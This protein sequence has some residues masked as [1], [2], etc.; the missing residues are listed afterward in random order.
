M[1]NKET[2]DRTNKELGYGDKSKI[3]RL[4]GIHKL[5][6]NRFF[7]GKEAELK[8]ET[9]SKIMDAALQ[10]IME[11]LKREKAQSKKINKL[12]D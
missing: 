10:L 12:L 2:I 11:R 4:A 1:T 5:S 3:A 7:N 9:Q 6:V 8:E